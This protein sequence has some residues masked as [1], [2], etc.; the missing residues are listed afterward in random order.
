VVV[1][2]SAATNR[3]TAISHRHVTGAKRRAIT[4]GPAA[5]INVRRHGSGAQMSNACSCVESSN[6]DFCRRRDPDG[7]WRAER[8][9]NSGQT[10]PHPW[11]VVT[12][13]SDI[14]TDWVGAM[15]AHALVALAFPRAGPLVDPGRPP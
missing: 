2:P 6:G 11:T 4:C 1:A 7:M 14:S 12:T 13:V 5:V 10:D 15:L 8:T 9:M 3:G